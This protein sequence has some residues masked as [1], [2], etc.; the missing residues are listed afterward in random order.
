MNPNSPYQNQSPA[1]QFAQHRIVDEQHQGLV[2]AAFAHPSEWRAGSKVVWNME[3]TSLPAQVFASAFN[4]DGMESFEFFPVQAFSW[5]EGDLTGV[6][7]GQNSHGLVRM[8]PRP[9][10][11]ALANLVIPHFRGDRQNLRV[12][13]VHPMQALSRIFNDPPTPQDESL[14]ARVEYEERGRAIEEEFYGVYSWNQ[15][16][17]GSVVQT[18]WGFGRLFSFRAERGQLD[19]LRQTFW[20]IAGSLQSNPQWKQAYDQVVQQLMAGFNVKIR[21]TYDRFEREKEAGRQNIAYND[22]LINQRNAQVSA[23][24]EQ[25]RQEIHERSPSPYT[26]QE[27]FGDLML[28]RT[29]F[30]DPNSAAGNYHY[31]QGSPQET[32]RSDQQEWYST[33]DPMDDPNQHKNGNWVRATPVKPSR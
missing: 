17:G 19:A 26:P 28:G 33:N 6:Q 32:W 9:A 21:A 2:V 1:P 11:D 13:G 29:P 5:I 22:Q 24:I 7:I 16:Q 31:E 10:P 30:H 15:A 3:H 12:T 25:T 4:P 18:N 14:M 23:S 8:Q 27:E 20:Q